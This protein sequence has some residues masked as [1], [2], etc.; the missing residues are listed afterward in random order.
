MLA[1]GIK[2]INQSNNQPLNN[3]INQSRGEFQLKTAKIGIL[4]IGSSSQ[5]D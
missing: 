5:I 1:I 2:S 4:S 3:S